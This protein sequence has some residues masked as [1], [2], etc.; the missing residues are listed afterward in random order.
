MSES[1]EAPSDIGLYLLCKRF[2]IKSTVNLAPYKAN[3]KY[4][5]ASHV[6]RGGGFS[7]GYLFLNDVMTNQ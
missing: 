4:N 3:D 5:T 2:V 7:P 6:M 1:G